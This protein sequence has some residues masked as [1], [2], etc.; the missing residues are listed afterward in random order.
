MIP[1]SFLYGLAL[2]VVGMAGLQSGG[3]PN[4]ARALGLPGLYFGGGIFLCSFFALREPRHGLAGASFLAFIAVVTN[5]ANLLGPLTS[6]EYQWATPAHRLTT[7][8]LAI[9][10]VYLACAFRWWKRARRAAAL[11]ALQAD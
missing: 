1:L 3:D 6:G 11:A 8:V 5:A 7:L 9:S 4:E 2:L 10:T